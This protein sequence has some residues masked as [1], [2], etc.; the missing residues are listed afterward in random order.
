MWIMDALGGVSVCVDHGCLRRWLCVWIMDALGDGCCVDLSN[1]HTYTWQL[2]PDGLRFMLLYFA[3]SYTVTI[4][5][6]S[7]LHNPAPF[8][9]L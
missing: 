8:R 2:I 3:C 4:C 9:P 1:V 6:G 5:Y 7:H